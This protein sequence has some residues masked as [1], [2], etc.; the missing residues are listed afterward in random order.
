MNTKLIILLILTSSFVFDA[1]AG[2][3][4]WNLNPATNDWN[5][6]T[7]WTPATVPN[8]T[9]DIATF[10]ASNTTS[11]L[12]SARINLASLVFAA[13][14]PSYT[15]TTGRSR[16]MT[17][18][19]EGVR[20]DSGMPQTFT[21]EFSFTGNSS[22]GNNV[23]YEIGGSVTLLDNASAERAS[24][25]DLAVNFFDNGTADH[26]V[27]TKASVEFHNNS[28]AADGTFTTETGGG[29]GGSIFFFDTSS[30]GNANFTLSSGKSA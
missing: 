16:T 10:A 29:G 30:A 4:T 22:A 23:S 26:A 12:T 13:S 6:S 27:F 19:D 28:T 14:A 11:V 3:A 7:N 18:G 21:G 8:S 1:H 2:S 20:N 25:N 15:I 17:F 9:T 24:F 5:T